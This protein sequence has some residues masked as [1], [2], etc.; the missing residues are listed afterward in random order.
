MARRSFSNRMA[1]RSIFAT[2]FIFTESTN[3]ATP[4]EAEERNER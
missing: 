3:E 4:R 2:N 1:T